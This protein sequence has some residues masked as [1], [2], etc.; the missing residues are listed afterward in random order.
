[1]DSQ[2]PIQFPTHPVDKKLLKPLRMLCPIPKLRQA[3][4]ARSTNKS[5]LRDANALNMPMGLESSKF[6]QIR[7]SSQPENSKLFKNTQ[8]MQLITVLKLLLKAKIHKLEDH[9]NFIP[10]HYSTGQE[11]MDQQN[12]LHLH[13]L[14]TLPRDKT[15]LQGYLSVFLPHTL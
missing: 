7:L 14:C 5:T 12:S 10:Y 2:S 9:Y 13:V 6:S 4:T 3:V 1:M 8:D 15:T 11:E